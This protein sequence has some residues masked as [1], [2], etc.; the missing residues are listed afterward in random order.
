MAGI[1]S[2]GLIH[3]LGTRAP[4]ASGDISMLGYDKPEM[5]QMELLYG[6]QGQLL[7]NFSNDLKQPDTQ[8][9][10]IVV[11][12]ALVAVGCFYFAR[13]LANDDDITSE[14]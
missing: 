8:A 4:D 13:L 11:F 7:E 5:R 2:A 12:S 9:I 10:I 3:R 1:V 6:K 14:K